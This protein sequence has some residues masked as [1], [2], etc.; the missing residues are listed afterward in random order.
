GQPLRET[1]HQL[2]PVGMFERQDGTTARF[3]IGD[4]G[5]GAVKGWRFGQ[6]SGAERPFTRIDAE[7][8]AAA[9]AQGTV[10]KGNLAPARGAETLALAQRFAAGDAERRKQKVRDFPI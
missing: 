10:E 4:D 6:A 9:I 2:Q 8:Q 7:R 5:A 1:R 3:V